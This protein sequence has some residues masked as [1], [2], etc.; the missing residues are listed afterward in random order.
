MC[1]TQ[2]TM[3]AFLTIPSVTVD[4]NFCWFL[5]CFCYLTRF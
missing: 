1:G 4:Q 3:H 5:W 2:L